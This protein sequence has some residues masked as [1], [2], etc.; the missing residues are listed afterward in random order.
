MDRKTKIL[1]IIQANPGIHVRGVIKESSFENGV[2]TH[3]LRQ[4]TEDGV[5]RTQKRSRYHRY[6]PVDVEEKEFPVIR[7]MRKPT[8]KEILFRIM[9]E[10]NPSFK[11]LTLKIDKSPSTISWNVSELVKE[12]VVEKCKKDGKQCYR[13]KDKE[14]FKK[15]FKK[16]FTKLFDEKLEHSEDIF[17]AL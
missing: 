6:Y 1:K 10:G 3:Y 13:V 2:V 9:V 17:L 8:K 15:T 16:E 5:V 14:L 12:G 4:L 11:D 7:N